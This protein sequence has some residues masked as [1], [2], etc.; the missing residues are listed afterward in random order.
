ML[1]FWKMNRKALALLAGAL[2]LMAYNQSW[3]DDSLAAQLAA[4]VGGL[5]GFRMIDKVS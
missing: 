5:T 3:I 4:I 2:I 1:K